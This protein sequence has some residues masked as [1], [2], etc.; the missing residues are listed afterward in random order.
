MALLSFPLWA[1]QATLS[2]EEQAEGFELLFNG[3]NLTGWIIQGL[4]GEKP[5]IADGEMRMDGWDWWA[6]ISKKK[7]KN[8]VLRC[9]AKIEPKGNT[10]ILFHTP[11]K[12]VFI[13]SPEI[14][15]CDDVGSE[16]SRECSGAIFK[17]LPPLKNAIKPAGEW[18]TVE[19]TVKDNHLTVI[20][21]GEKVQDVDL[22][23]VPGIIHKREEGGI[24]LQHK[25]FKQK[26][27]FRNIRIKAL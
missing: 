8:F 26:A 27:A 23:G 5:S 2:P 11:E 17:T 13:T 21:N 25:S 7:F 10:G 9:E 4:E 12:E 18:N 15:L 1:A 22:K 20:L 24:A 19:V 3:E 16:P 6:I 14:Q